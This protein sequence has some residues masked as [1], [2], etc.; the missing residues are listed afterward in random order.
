MSSIDEL[1]NLLEERG[2]ED[3]TFF[4]NPDYVSAVVGLTDDGKIIYDY[5]KMITHLM[6]TDKM[7]YDEAMEFIDYNTIRTIPYMGDSH[8]II[9]SER[10]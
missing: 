3:T 6:E 1:K 8:P 9:L 7:E 10:L 4:V 5:E 2:L